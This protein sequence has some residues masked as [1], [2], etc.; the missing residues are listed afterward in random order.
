MSLLGLL[1]LSG[2]LSWC[3]PVVCPVLEE[4]GVVQQSKDVRTC[5]FDPGHDTESCPAGIFYISGYVR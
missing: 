2:L 3:Y 4:I 1:G 5:P